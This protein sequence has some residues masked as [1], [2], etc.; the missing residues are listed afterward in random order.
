MMESWGMAIRVRFLNSMSVFGFCRFL[1]LPANFPVS[2]P[3]AQQWLGTRR[4]NI[5][6]WTTFLNSSNFKVPPSLP[7]LSKRILRNIEYFQSNYLFVF[8]GLII[9]CL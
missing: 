2:A 8:I 3:A 4:E 1:Q 5:R 9:Y 6:P 7:R